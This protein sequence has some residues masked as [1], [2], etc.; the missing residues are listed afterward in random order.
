[1]RRSTVTTAAA[2]YKPLHAAGTV[3]TSTVFY[4]DGREVVDSGPVK[5]KKSEAPV[6]GLKT[7][8]V[9]GPILQIVL[10]D[11]A[12]NK[13]A[14]SHWEQSDAAQWAV[15]AYSVPQENSHYQ[16]TYCCVPDPNNL[17]D[18]RKEFR[19]LV[20]YHGEIA[21]DPATG[22]IR[23]ITAQADFK[24]SD[25]L[26]KADI[27]VEY[28]PVDIG[29][30]TYTCPTKSIAVSRAVLDTTSDS[31][32]SESSGAVLWQTFL[33]DVQFQDYHLF[34]ATT[35]I[36][37]VEKAS[38]AGGRSGTAVASTAGDASQPAADVEV[39]E[40]AAPPPEPTAPPPP[41]R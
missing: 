22:V 17:V 4:R 6:P 28:A 27:L 38:T 30:Y 39:A 2:F 16:V 8:G 31:V 11:A 9:F 18:P 13:L 21:V 24:P 40:A 14:W 19:Q 10:V 12:Q 34:H 33:N 29:G 5:V 37:P 23:R 25:P 41:P 7:Q 32:G 36:V 35:K 3:T 26:S 15:F 1:M 20:G